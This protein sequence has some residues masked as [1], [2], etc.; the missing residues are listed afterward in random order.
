M[1]LEDE[2]G[3]E[4]G[5]CIDEFSA[6]SGEGFVDITRWQTRAALHRDP[7]TLRHELLDRLRRGGDARLVRPRFGRHSD[8]QA[9][10]ARCSG[11]N[12]FAW[13]DTNSCTLVAG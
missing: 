10:Q 5:V 8:M 11:V 13:R 3:G 1:N 9:V 12:A 7:V 4:G 6:G 2:I